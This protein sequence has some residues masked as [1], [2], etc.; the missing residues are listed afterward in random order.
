[1]TDPVSIIGCG[2]TGL[3]LAR[4]L[5]SS[6]ARARGFASRP[7][8]LRQ[9]AAAG[10]EALPL[11]LDA[12][13]A[14][15]DFTG[16]LVYYAVPP[17]REAGDPRLERF[18]ACIRGAPRRLVYLSTTGVYGDQ[19]GARVDEETP[20][21]PRTERAMRRLAAETAV[22][23]WA[24]AQGVSWTVLRVPGIYGPGRLPLDRLRPR[25]RAARGLAG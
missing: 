13:V 19:A 12:A 15:I 3:R 17:A 20:P 10:I 21:A 16:H 25:D 7:E 4:R 22:R 11:D 5:R 24:L 14:P 2:Y 23:G 6:G 18:L 9:I 8:S 1:V